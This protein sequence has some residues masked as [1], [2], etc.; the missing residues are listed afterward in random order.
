MI[1]P[2]VGRIVHFYSRA[3]VEPEAAIVT[4]VRGDRMVNLTVFDRNGDSR[5]A[6]SV[7]LVQD[8]DPTPTNHY[9]EWMPYQK[10]QAAK[11][12]ALEAKLQG[13]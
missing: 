5:A 2:N 6:T 4:Y 7:T 3:H 1:T 13:A 11:T 8:G 10:G 9:A 12:E